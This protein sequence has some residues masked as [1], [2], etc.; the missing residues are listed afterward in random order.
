MSRFSITTAALAGVWLLVAAGCVTPPP[1]EIQ[2]VARGMS[3]VLAADPETR[4]PTIHLRAGERVRVM[5]R[6]D[7]PGLIHDFQIPAWGVKTESIRAGETTELVFT[8]PNAPGLTEYLCR[9]HAE[10]MHGMVEVIAP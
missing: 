2:L 7:A 3:F 5:F 8:A 9:P 6:N 10:L 4:N 1:R